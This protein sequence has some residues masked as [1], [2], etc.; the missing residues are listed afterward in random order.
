MVSW[1]RRAR[2]QEVMTTIRCTNRLLKELGTKTTIALAQPSGLSDWHANLLWFDRKKCVLF[3][4]DLTLYS[5]LIHMVKKPLSAGFGE[6]FRLGL[7]K[8]LMSDGLDNPQVRRMLGSQGSI[9]ITKTNSRSILGSMNDLAFQIKCI[10][11]SKGGLAIADLFEINRQMNETPMSAIKYNVGIEEL[12][13]RLVEPESRIDNL[14][15]QIQ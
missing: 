13:R 10:V 9:I 8:S 14:G 6:L 4:N 11:H 5:F 7:L 1:E 2:I 3:T 15:P 12:R